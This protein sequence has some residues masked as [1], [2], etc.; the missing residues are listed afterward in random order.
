MLFMAPDSSKL[1]RAQGCYVSDTELERLVRYWKGIQI[2]QPLPTDVR[3]VQRPLWEDM[4]EVGAE[5]KPDEEDN[6]LEEAVKIVQEQKRA[7]VSLLQRRLRI[8]YSRASRLI[9]LMEEKGIVGPSPGG[10][11]P[12]EVLVDAEGDES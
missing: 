1:V 2:E 10:S 8:G 9:D 5:A 6:L 7:S 3:L 12:R 11:R 4:M